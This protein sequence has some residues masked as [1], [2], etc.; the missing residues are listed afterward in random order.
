MTK[1]LLDLA[2]ITYIVISIVCAYGFFL[3]LMWLK[4]VE[5]K[6]VYVYVMM[7]IFSIFIVYTGNAYARYLFLI[8]MCGEHNLY[9][10][11]IQG[12]FWQSRSLLILAFVSA[13]IWRM[14]NRARK[15]IRDANEIE[16]HGHRRSTDKL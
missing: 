15:T 8:D 13:I 4:A 11:F 9:E 7:L 5:H 10:D 16:K 2:F 14:H 1:E 12:F 6:E 3:F